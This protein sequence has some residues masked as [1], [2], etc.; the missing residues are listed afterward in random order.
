MIAAGVTVGLGG[1]MAL[2]RLLSVQL[3]EVSARD[4]RTLAATA[5]V[6]SAVALG[7]AWLPLRRATAV[8][9]VITLRAE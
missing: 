2:S 8:D 3:Y 9:P 4:P 7:S 6:L 1:A 5:V